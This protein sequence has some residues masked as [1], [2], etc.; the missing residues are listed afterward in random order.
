MDGAISSQIVLHVA[1]FYVGFWHQRLE[2]DV[3][4]EQKWLENIFFNE[5][6]G[7]VSLKITGN[8]HQPGAR[9]WVEVVISISKKK[10]LL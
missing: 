10:C 2:N 1:G 7:K 5:K 9:V 8:I 4:F 3:F 6:A